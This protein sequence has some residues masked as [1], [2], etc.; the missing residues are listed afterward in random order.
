[1]PQS[2]LHSQPARRLR[3][4]AGAITV[5]RPKRFPSRSIL[6]DIS[7]AHFYHLFTS[8]DLWRDPLAEHLAALHDS[9]FDG[10]FTVGLVGPPDQRRE[11]LYELNVI[12]PP[13][14]LIEADEGYEQVTIRPLHSYA[15]KHAGTVL[16]AHTKG[17]GFPHPAQAGWRRT[18]TAY[19][20]KN[21][22]HLAD[23]LHADGYDAAGCH[24][25]QPGI[26]RLPGG[27]TAEA[28]FAMFGGNFWLATT[29]YLRRLPECAGN[30]RFDAEAW[31][32]LGEPRVLDLF[33]GYPTEFPQ[34][35]VRRMVAGR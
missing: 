30:T 24:W 1:L 18:M 21:W 31:I 11:A 10:P 16:Y 35:P 13:D 22:R 28:P 15:R 8:S 12:R 23:Q 27:G 17:A 9:Q 19:V 25:L 5:R 32:A 6:A 7:V 4:S 2:H 33:P 3:D 26:Y 20:V 34:L 29:T 14:T